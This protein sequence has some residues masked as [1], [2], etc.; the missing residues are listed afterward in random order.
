MELL[1]MLSFLFIVLISISVIQTVQSISM[2]ILP[3]RYVWKG[4]RGHDRMVV[5]FTT[6]FAMSA[7]HH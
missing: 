1:A 5:G 4:H 3:L 6:E 7:Y 2:Q